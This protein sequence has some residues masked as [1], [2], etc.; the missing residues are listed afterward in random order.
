MMPCSVSSASQ[1]GHP[2]V[3]TGSKGEV[4]EVHK[5]MRNSITVMNAKGGVGKS[6]L[7]LALAETLSAYHDK[8]VLVVDADAQASISHL[9]MRQDE[10][11]AAQSGGR[12]LVGYL[13]GAVLNGS[14][15]SWREFVVPDVSDVDD[16][17]SIA[18]MPSDTSLTL[19]EREIS[20]RDHEAQLRSAI[21]AFLE[22]AGQSYDIV[23]IDSAPGLSVLTE[24]FLREADFYLSPT[25]PD[26]V[27]TRGLKFLRAFQQRNPEMGFA[28]NLGVVI[29]IKDLH[30]PEDAQFDQWLRQD[31]T[32]RCFQQS[33]PQVAPLRSAKFVA[34]RLRSYLAKYPGATGD[35]LRDITSE[36]LSRL[37]ASQSKV[38]AADTA[39]TSVEGETVTGERR[40]KGGEGMVKAMW[41]SWKERRMR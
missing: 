23:L 9:L 6:T 38:V 25:K 27:S 24:C 37:A 7:V 33:I 20:K 1:P 31:S 26:Y 30:S 12:T 32:H 18:L 5:R 16:A 28:E 40:G 10:L 39:T 11:E 41:S 34:T 29:N 14:A 35:L 36:L 2:A 4:V 3:A 21:A 17:R 22:E 8:D 15:A 19:F 13:T